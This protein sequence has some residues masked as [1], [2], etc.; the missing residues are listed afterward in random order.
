MK[1]RLLQLWD[2]LYYFFE[3]VFI[4]MGYMLM[5]LLFLKLFGWISKL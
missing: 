2:D 3:P 1:Q 4:V 5:M